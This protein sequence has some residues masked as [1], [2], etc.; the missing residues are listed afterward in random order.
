MI[1]VIIISIPPTND[2]SQFLLIFSSGV[3][4]VIVIKL[5]PYQREIMNIFVGLTLQIL[6]LATLLPLADKVS[7][8]L[9]LLLQLF[10]H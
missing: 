6:V 8:Q 5:N 4:A 10:Y 9:L 1:I 3:L 7:Q 2:L